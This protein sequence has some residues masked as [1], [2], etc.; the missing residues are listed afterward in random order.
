MKED[1]EEKDEKGPEDIYK[2]FFEV[3]LED[4]EK[5]KP[6]AESL[7]VEIILSLKKEPEHDS[8]R[9]LLEETINESPLYVTIINPDG[10][11][12]ESYPELEAGTKKVRRIVYDECIEPQQLYDVVENGKLSLG[13]HTI[14]INPNVKPGGHT[15]KAYIRTDN[16]DKPVSA[17]LEYFVYVEGKP[18][19]S[20]S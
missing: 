1:D 11:V 8:D 7:D 13:K 18:K 10:L 16:I 15:L 2:D 19:K 14:N 17:S 5:I 6:K 3:R 9:G 20:S 12:S 4:P